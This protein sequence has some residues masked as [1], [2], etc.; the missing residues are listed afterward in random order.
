MRG[1]L[2][3]PGMK[4]RPLFIYKNKAYGM[5]RKLQ[6]NWYQWLEDFV[7][8]PW[9]VDVHKRQAIRSE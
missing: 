6:M 1:L 2:I 3:L 4:A 7:W 5:G 8:G 9:M